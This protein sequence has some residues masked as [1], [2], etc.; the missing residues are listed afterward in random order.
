MIHSISQL[1]NFY[2]GSSIDIKARWG[3]HL[4]NLKKG[5]HHSKRLQAIFNNNGIDDIVFTVIQTCSDSDIFAVEQKYIS[6]LKPDLNTAKIVCDCKMA[7]LNSDWLNTHRNKP[8]EVKFYRDGCFF[9]SAC[10]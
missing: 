8:V 4:H 9:Y 10:A 3:T 6:L 1:E 5:S 2:I 7:K